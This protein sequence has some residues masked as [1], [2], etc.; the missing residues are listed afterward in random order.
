VPAVVL[1]VEQV[2]R[3]VELAE[4]VAEGPPAAERAAVAAWSGRPEASA[5]ASAWASAR[6]G[7]IPSSL[8]AESDAATTRRARYG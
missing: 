8:T 4:R 2:E 6:H 3:V 7:S 1:P 5:S